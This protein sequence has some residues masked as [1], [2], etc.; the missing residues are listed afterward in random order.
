MGYINSL[1]GAS[2]IL[3]VMGKEKGESS[4]DLKEGRK[5]RGED[6]RQKWK[7]EEKWE[8]RERGQENEEGKQAVRPLP[9]RN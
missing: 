1:V 9:I 7:V 5:K 4:K 6:R 3:E 2:G 8:K